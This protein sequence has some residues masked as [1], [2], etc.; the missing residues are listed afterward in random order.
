ME[1]QGIIQNRSFRTFLTVL[2]AAFTIFVILV[3]FPIGG[4]RVA[5]IGKD[6]ANIIFSLIAFWYFYSAWSTSD[7]RDVS[8]QIWGQ[9]AAGI[10]L[11]AVAEIIWGYYEVFLEIEVPYPSLA[12]LLWIP[13][14]LP[15]F[16][17]LIMRYRMFNVKLD[18]R[19]VF[20]LI[21]VIVLFLLATIYFVIQPIVTEFDP[22]RLFESL[23]NLFYPMGDL[24]LFVLAT[25]I[26][27]SFEKGRFAV[28]WMFIALGFITVSVS[29][30]IFS[31]TS[32]YGYYYPDGNINFISFFVDA[33]Y[34]LSYLLLA[35][36]IYA[37]NLLLKA[38]YAITINPISLEEDKK[39]SILIITRAD[40]SVITFS[41]N[42]LLLVGKGDKSQI[43]NAPLA[44]ALQADPASI[45]RVM[46]VVVKEGSICNYPLKM[47]DGSSPAVLLTALALIN[48]QNEYTG[49]GI[50]LQAD[51]SSLNEF[52]SPLSQ[53]QKGLV[54]SFLA[55]AGANLKE[56]S[57][58]L[59]YYFLE[60][61]RLLFSLVY[62][63]NGQSVADM[64]LE[65]ITQKSKENEWKINMDNGQISISDEY[66]GK[67]LA[68]T[69]SRLLQEVKTA[70]S[71]VISPSLVVN[72]MQIV[73]QNVGAEVLNIIDRYGVRGGV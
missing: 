56:E 50:V 45:D 70:A 44:Q 3:L 35:L 67:A 48:P 41:E 72:E 28:T 52:E 24:I 23:L 63:L 16:G 12:D 8:K 68:D 14:Y 18:T 10:L 29:D 62:E 27:F 22:E 60:Q 9:F 37:Y 2:S 59:R 25:L 53:E 57:R 69:I 66:E 33:T 46:Q 13:G 30:L 21:L 11:W 32:W 15:L 4:G 7:A 17:G 26:L 40:S 43:E 49:A 65:T 58:V 61:I 47:N 64:L 34:A 42:L 54:D 31:Y 51:L 73:D 39:S 38:R 1:S 5:L 6:F 19:Q 36:G 20:S 55:K 71:R